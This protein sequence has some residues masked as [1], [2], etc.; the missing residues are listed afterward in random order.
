MIE[1][2][3]TRDYESKN[4]YITSDSILPGSIPVNIPSSDKR[5][6]QYISLFLHK[7]DIDEAIRFLEYD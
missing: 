5:K 3:F 4:I 6:K 7:E 2:K 1:Y